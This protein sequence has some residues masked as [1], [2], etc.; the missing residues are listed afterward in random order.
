[1]ATRD[2]EDLV[3]DV[4]EECGNFSRSDLA[5]HAIGCVKT[6]TGEPCGVPSRLSRQMM[7]RLAWVGHIHV[8]PT[9]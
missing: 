3:G 5:V 1:M 2:V 8:K 4:A 6:A 9:R 7:F